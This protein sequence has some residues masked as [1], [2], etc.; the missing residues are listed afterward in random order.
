[1]YRQGMKLYTHAPSANGWK[2]EVA[3][4]Q[5]GV[6]FERI[7]VAIF[8]GGSHTPEFLR[9]NPA[10][11]VPV[12]ELDDGTCL[13]ESNAI[14]WHVT[15]GTW[16]QPED[17]AAQAR[18]LGWLMFEQNQIEPVIGSARYWK[19]TG[20]DRGR[21]DEL[22]RRVEQGARALR[23]LDGHLASRDWLV[24][25]RYSLADIA[26]YA[27]G[28]VAPDVGIDL[29]ATPAVARWFARVEAQ[30]GW[31]PGPAPYGADAMIG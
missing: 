8:R 6:P 16:L 10:G 2:V 1:M 22:R 13:P 17:A 26:V 7:D 28:H 11:S 29:A 31:F 30:P 4:A 20:R 18:A 21:E 23:A 15:R 25:D 12:L 5:L 19:L 3:L 14:L 9:K 27:Y 24:G